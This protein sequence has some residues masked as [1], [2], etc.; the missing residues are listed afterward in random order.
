[1]SVLRWI[2]VLRF[3]IVLF[4]TIIFHVGAIGGYVNDE[5]AD[6]TKGKAVVLSLMCIL[7]NDFI[8]GQ[9]GQNKGR[10]KGCKTRRRQYSMNTAHCIS[11]ERVE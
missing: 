4:A 8:S 11:K 7:L 3:L 1:M 10:I 2:V 6:D 9:G 5:D